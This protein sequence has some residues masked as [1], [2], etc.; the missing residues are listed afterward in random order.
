MKKKLGI[1]KRLLITETEIYL[2][3]PEK[4]KSETHRLERIKMR[5]MSVYSRAF[6]WNKAAVFEK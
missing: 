3:K 4:E 1:Q 6:R 2:D 5:K